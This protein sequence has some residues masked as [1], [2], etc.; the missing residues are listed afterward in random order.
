VHKVYHHVTDD[1]AMAIFKGELTHEG[2][3]ASSGPSLFPAVIDSNTRNILLDVTG[4]DVW[5]LA[6]VCSPAPNRK[7]AIWRLHD[8]CCDVCGLSWKDGIRLARHTT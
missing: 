3:E 4:V 7:R 1:V 2:P 5:S 6:S 8:M